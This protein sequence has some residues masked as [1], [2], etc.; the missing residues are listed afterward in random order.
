L[1][2]VQ[3]RADLFFV[4]PK[5]DNQKSENRQVV[6]VVVLPNGRR[7]HLLDRDAYE[8]ALRAAIERRTREEEVE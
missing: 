8:A 4:R 3:E 6:R 2:D 1:D 5:P 7:G